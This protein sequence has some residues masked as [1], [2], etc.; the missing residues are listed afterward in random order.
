V[1]IHCIIVKDNPPVTFAVVSCETQNVNM[2]VLQVFGLSGE[3]HV[4]AKEMWDLMKL[5]STSTFF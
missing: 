2:T 1:C 3:N 4:S 5:V